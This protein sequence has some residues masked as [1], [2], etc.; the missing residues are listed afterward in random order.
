LGNPALIAAASNPKLV[1][2]AGKVVPVVIEQQRRVVRTG[3]ILMGG[4][5][6]A[7]LLYFGG[8]YLR[9]QAKKALYRR[10]ATDPNVK[11]AVDIFEA[12]PE[13]MKSDTGTIFTPGQLITDLVNNLMFWTKSDSDRIL[14]IAQRI[15]DMNETARAFRLLYD[16]DLVP[17]LQKAMS[18]DD[19]DRFINDA[20]RDKNFI[21]T[22]Y[23]AANAGK[24]A[25][26]KNRTDII[27]YVNNAFIRIS[28]LDANRWINGYTTGKTYEDKYG[29][30][31]PPG[32][33]WLE[34]DIAY[35]KQKY[36]TRAAVKKND[37]TLYPS[38][39]DPQHKP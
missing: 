16:Q 2:A 34:M 29:A 9:K 25:G 33:V 17:L 13:R 22:T 32:T 11:A 15:T 37:V 23:T 10:A 3:M 8:K 14:L 39:A 28:T 5:T 7:A 21:P 19:F 27:T 24:I 30:I 31:S 4:V 12:I 20:N 6:A 26:T 38:T 1:E 18:P 36:G 35:V